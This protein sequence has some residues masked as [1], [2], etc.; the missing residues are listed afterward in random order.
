MKHLLVALLLA[1]LACSSKTTERTVRVAAAADLS[2]AFD[3]IGRAFEARTGIKPIVDFGSSGLLAKQI[4]DGAPYAL[5]AAAN[6]SYAHK[7]VASGHCDASSLARYARGRL[8]VWTP[9]GVQAPERIEDLADARFHRIA[10]A[11]PDHAPYGVAAKQA[12]EH[13]GI[14]SQVEPR[15]VLGENIQ[16]TMKYAQ[17]GAVDAAVVALSLAVISTGGSA[18]RVDPSLHDPLDQALVVCGQGEEADAARQ[19]VAFIQS[20]AGREI[21]TRYGFL[22]PGEKLSGAEDTPKPSEPSFHLDVRV[23]GTSTSWQQDVFERTARAVGANKNSD[24]DARDTWS[25]R[26][27]VRGTYGASARVVAVVGDS[28][29][30]IDASEWGDVS[31]TP[32]VHSTRR[33]HLNFCWA[34]GAGKWGATIVK[35]VTALEIQR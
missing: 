27:L 7:A 26:E 31:R 9:S 10:I 22:L 1:T 18:L 20:P 16:A 5:F 15:L 24:G 13:A 4:E 2:R 34:D 28:R 33:G 35:N 30:A 8:V 17:T 11:N 32:I 29:T 21:M 19:L 3:E 23:D 12:L 6:E 25:V 14:W